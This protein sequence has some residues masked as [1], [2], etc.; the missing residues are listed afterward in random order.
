MDPI[1][2][3]ENQEY[4]IER[5]VSYKK[6]KGRT[7]YQAR[8]RGYDATE[9]SWLSEEDLANAFDLFLAYQLRHGT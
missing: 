7:V 6:T 2:G 1:V 4:E 8:W 3:G 5:F 9:D